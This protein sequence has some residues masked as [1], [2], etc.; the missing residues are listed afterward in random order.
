MSTRA[1][2]TFLVMVA[3]V[4]IGVL[5]AVAIGDPLLGIVTTYD[6]GGMQ[7]Q[8]TQIHTFLVKYMGIAFIG[9]ALLWAIFR[10]LREE[11][12]QV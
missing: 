10:I 9:V 6:L 11:R 12:Q 4:P 3:M 2:T 8:A 7:G 1:I 5:L